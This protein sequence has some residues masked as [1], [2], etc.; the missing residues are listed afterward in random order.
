MSMNSKQTIAPFLWFDNNAED[1]TKHHSSIIE[2]S[3]VPQAQRNGPGRRG[4]HGSVQVPHKS[5][6][7]S[8]VSVLAAAIAAALVL[9]VNAWAGDFFDKDDAALHGYDPVAHFTD[10]KPVKGSDEYRTE[11]KGSVFH[12]ASKAN[13]DAFVAE[14]DKN[15][16][17]VSSQTKVQD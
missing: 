11:F 1:A 2:N 6:L 14:A 7:W 12:F 13:R 17:A 4:S 15:W 10:N 16:P 5:S 8:M 9:V 3:R